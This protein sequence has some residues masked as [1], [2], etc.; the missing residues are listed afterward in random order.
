MNT[1]K[2]IIYPFYEKSG[3]HLSAV[4]PDI[5]TPKSAKNFKNAQE[6]APA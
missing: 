4:C 5:S 1:G 2:I 6:K 3:A